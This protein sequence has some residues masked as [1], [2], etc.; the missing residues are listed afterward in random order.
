MD[1]LLLACILEG[2][3][4]DPTLVSGIQFGILVLVLGV[5]EDGFLLHAFFL[6]S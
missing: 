5:A 4:F 3:E 1:G 6:K 2:C